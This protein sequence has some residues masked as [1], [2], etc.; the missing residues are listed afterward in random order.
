ME[1]L[2]FA[3]LKMTSGSHGVRKLLRIETGRRTVH[4][5]TRAFKTHLKPKTVI[6]M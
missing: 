6:L 4:C 2:V 1:L 3:F 5:H